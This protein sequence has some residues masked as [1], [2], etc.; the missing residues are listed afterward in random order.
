M[1]GHSDV[2]Q[3]PIMEYMSKSRAVYTIAHASL[4]FV[5][6][7]LYSTLFLGIPPAM[8]VSFIVPIVCSIIITMAI[9]VTSAFAP[10]FTNREFYPTVIAT[11]MIAVIGIITACLTTIIL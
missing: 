2:I 5:G 4:I 6:S 9:A 10:L 8:S 7:C 3:G 11:S 1:E